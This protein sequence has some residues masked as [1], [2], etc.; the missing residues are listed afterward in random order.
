MRA[1]RWSRP[2][3]AGAKGP[4]STRRAFCA[5]AAGACVFPAFAPLAEVASA[6][7]RRGRALVKL[8]TLGEFPDALV[9]AIAR[10]LEDELS[11]AIERLPAR[12]LPRAAYYPPR[13]RYRADRLL[14]HLRTMLDGAP[15]TT[16]VLGFTSVDISTTK[17]P[18][19]DWGVLGLGDLG[20][21]ACVI[22]S[23]RMRRNVRDEEHL[24]FRVV[25][26]AVHEVGHTLGLAHCDEP[27]CLM[28]DAHG[29]IV[30]VDTSTGRLGPRCRAFVESSAPIVDLGR[31]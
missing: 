13:R 17:P 12:P 7:P 21:R 26:T 16:R 8:V 4:A 20:G 28:N 2:D 24:R 1:T 6:Q 3:G 11:V 5:L 30:T 18:Y 15:P 14:D 19:R 27:R 22:S 9:D 10:G 31:G 25:T 23:H 29:S